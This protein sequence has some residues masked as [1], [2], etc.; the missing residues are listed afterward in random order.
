[1][2]TKSIPM[3]KLSTLSLLFLLPFVACKKENTFKKY[4][5]SAVSVSNNGYYSS[6]TARFKALRVVM[7]Q[8]EQVYYSKSYSSPQNDP[9]Y[10]NAQLEDSV[11]ALFQAGIINVTVYE[12]NQKIGEAKADF[13]FNTPYIYA[14]MDTLTLNASMT[15]QK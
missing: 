13:P 11:S 10:Y 14:I 8:G 9:Y 1:M 5:P 4:K 7:I 12:Q 6:G 2:Y 15:E 3:R